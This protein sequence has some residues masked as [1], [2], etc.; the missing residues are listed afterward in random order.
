[1]KTE[2]LLLKIA[3]QNDRI[4]PTPQSWMKLSEVIG[5]NK[6]ND[7]LTPLIL[8]GWAFSSDEEKQ[9]RL[10]KQI[11]YAYTQ[12]EEVRDRFIRVLCSIRESDWH[13][14]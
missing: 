4:C 5:K 12:P 9:E 1:M 8:N 2:K 13:H 10:I 6:P 14:R 3:T 7:E 11:N